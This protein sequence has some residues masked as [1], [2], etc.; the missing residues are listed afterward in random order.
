MRRRSLSRIHAL[1]LTTDC[2]DCT[3]RRALDEVSARGWAVTGW[4]P[5]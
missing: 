4:W 2:T 5:K 1:E 3:D